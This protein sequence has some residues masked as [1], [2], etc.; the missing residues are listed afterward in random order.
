MQIFVTPLNVT[1]F[2]PNVINISS[3]N[4][5]N[6]HVEVIPT[7]KNSLKALDFRVYNQWGEMIFHTTDVNGAWDGTAS[8]TVQPIGVYVYVVKA[9]TLDGKIINKKGSI[10]LVK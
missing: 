4:H 10:T 3:S 6:N 9:T 2:V 8:G 1:I 5:L 7:P